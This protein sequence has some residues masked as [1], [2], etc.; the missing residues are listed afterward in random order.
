MGTLYRLLAS[1]GT[2]SVEPFWHI[3]DEFVDTSFMFPCGW[4]KGSEPIVEE[5]K[6]LGLQN[7][8]RWVP[9]LWSSHKG[10]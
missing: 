1:S 4:T 7:L 10:T 9:I 3:F 6:E 5:M 8:Q 2:F